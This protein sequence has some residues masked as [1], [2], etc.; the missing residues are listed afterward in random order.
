MGSYIDF[1]AAMSRDCQLTPDVFLFTNIFLLLLFL[2]WAAL[3]FEIGSGVEIFI[4]HH[5]FV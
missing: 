3:A 4:L 5:Q 1:A 2:I